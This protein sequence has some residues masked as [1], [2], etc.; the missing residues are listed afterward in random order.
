MSRGLV[1]DLLVLRY[2]TR[3]RRPTSRLVA[4]WFKQSNWS[5]CEVLWFKGLNQLATVIS[6]HSA[7]SSNLL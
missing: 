2:G 4:V 7:L 1:W 3:S 5:G 6:S